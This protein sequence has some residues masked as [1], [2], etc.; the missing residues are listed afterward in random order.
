MFYKWLQDGE[1]VGRQEKRTSNVY[2]RNSDTYE[3]F[4]YF[5]VFIYIRTR[6][7]QKP[8]E[9]RN[10]IRTNRKTCNS[11][12]PCWCPLGWSPALPPHW[13]WTP[14]K[15]I[16]LF[17][18]EFQERKTHKITL[19]RQK[20]EKETKNVRPSFNL[21]FK[22]LENLFLYSRGCHRVFSCGGV[23]EVAVGTQVVLNI[24][25]WTTQVVLNQG[26]INCG[27]SS[28]ADFVLS[29]FLS[30]FLPARWADWNN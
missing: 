4:S 29:Y 15:Q 5:S 23:V 3:L 28:Q 12:F 25:Q 9:P 20:K 27:S 30:N 22:V 7:Y 10:T 26:D 8:I 1:P 14:R 6:K 18:G 17:S 19:F 16:F 13:W 2:K 21:S 11:S 24:E